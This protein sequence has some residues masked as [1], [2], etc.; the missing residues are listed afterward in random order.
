[1][2]GKTSV[3]A[4]GMSASSLSSDGPQSRMASLMASAVRVNV[5]SVL[6]RMISARLPGK[7]FSCRGARAAICRRQCRPEAIKKPSQNSA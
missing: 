2:G 6:L 4:S 3:P 5:S 7:G 1:M